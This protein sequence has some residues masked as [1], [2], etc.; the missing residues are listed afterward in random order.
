M[1]DDAPRSQSPR[2]AR[3]CLIAIIFV[4]IGIGLLH[5]NHLISTK[6]DNASYIY[7]AESIAGAH[8]YRDL[9]LKEAPTHA[10]YPPMVSLLLTPVILVFGVAISKLKLVILIC[11][12]LALW[13]IYRL[14]EE[15]EGHVVAL[16]VVAL[17][18]TLPPLMTY[19]SKIGRAHV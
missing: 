9:Y 17:T 6:D 1:N 2:W 5:N 14:I 8:G 3:R 15:D 19:S 10:L 4:Y 12:C 16:S 18:A 7:L 13:F 11:G